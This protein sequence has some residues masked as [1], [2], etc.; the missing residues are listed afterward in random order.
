MLHYLHYGH[1]IGSV[2]PPDE[3]MSLVAIDGIGSEHPYACFEKVWELAREN[4][5]SARDMFAS[6]GSSIERSLS[7]LRAITSVLRYVLMPQT[8]LDILHLSGSIETT[9]ADFIVATTTENGYTKL[10]SVAKRDQ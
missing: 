1:P 8:G 3:S 5:P 10:L 4:P 2:T 7:I 6:K 9:E